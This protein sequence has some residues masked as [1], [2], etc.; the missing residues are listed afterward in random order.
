[1]R[2]ARLFAVAA[3]LAML[4]AAPLAH[5]CSFSWGPGS[6]PAEIRVRDDVRMVRGTFRF[7]EARGEVGEDGVLVSGW[8]YGRIETRRGT[9]WNTIQPY[10]QFLVECAAYPRPAADANGIFWIKRHGT[11]GRYELL[12]WEGEYLARPEPRQ[13]EG[14]R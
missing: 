12:L 3:C 7:G 4:A 8:I 10:H 2:R 13:Q 5:A 11:D 6:S 14:P 9:H 1:M